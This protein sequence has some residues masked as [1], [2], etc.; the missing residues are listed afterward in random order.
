MDTPA[1]GINPRA[2]RAFDI[3]DSAA[4]R[5]DVSWGPT[6]TLSGTGLFRRNRGVFG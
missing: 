2:M 3:V 1:P 5:M 6:D 4:F